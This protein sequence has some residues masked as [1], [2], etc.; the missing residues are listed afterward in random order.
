MKTIM[1]NLRQKSQV[2]FSLV[3][4]MI[5]VAIIGI[6]SAVAIPNFKKYQ[7]KSKTSEAKLQL[8]SLYTAMNSWYADYSN[9]ATCLNQMGFDV[10]QEA[11]NRY[12]A[13]GFA[14]K[15]DDGN[16]ASVNNGAPA[17]CTADV[18]NDGLPVV[19]TA[20]VFV[21]GALKKVSNNNVSAADFQAQATVKYTAEVKDADLLAATSA[22]LSNTYSFFRAGAVG[23]V[24]SKSIPEGTEKVDLADTWTIDSNKNLKSQVIGY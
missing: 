16:A 1:S 14:L 2:G 19:G 18:V 13:V 21:Y 24:D 7:A 3:E 17:S 8:A 4:L 23:H 20:G 9:Y 10:S 15:S 11:G 5:V 6:L 22:G 12:Y